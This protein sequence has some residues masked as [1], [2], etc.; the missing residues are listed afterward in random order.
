MENKQ[1]IKAVER[2]FAKEKNRN[3]NGIEVYPKVKGDL[4]YIN[5]NNPSNLSYNPYCILNFFYNQFDVL[6]KLL[7][8]KPE[9]YYNLITG[10]NIVKDI[11]LN[12]TDK[13]NLDK[14]IDDMNTREHI[15]IDYIDITVLF[16]FE[17]FKLFTEPES[18]TVEVH[19]L[20]H[21]SSDYDELSWWYYESSN[22]QEDCYK[23]IYPIVDYLDSNPLL[24]DSSSMYMNTNIVLNNID[25]YEEWVNNSEK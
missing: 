9:P 17:S 3:L 4:I 16:S 2:F 23:I 8:I 6:C 12:E 22:Y 15:K 18:L 21:D 11:Y 7:S 13:N 24:Y 5:F 10:K 25:S 1:V 14:I 19:S 20:V